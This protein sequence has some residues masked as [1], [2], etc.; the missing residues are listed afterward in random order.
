M[1]QEHLEGQT[2]QERIDRG[3]VPLDEALGLAGEMAE[4]LAAAHQAGIVH[5]DLKPANIFITSG[6]HAKI[7]DFGPGTAA[8]LRHQHHR[9]C[10]TLLFEHRAVAR[11]ASHRLRGLRLF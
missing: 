11:R 2:L 7:L 3:A 5:R 4:A 9:R 6:G 8:D 10:P 1:V